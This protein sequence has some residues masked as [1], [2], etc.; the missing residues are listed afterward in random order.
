MDYY[1]LGPDNQ[2]YGPADEATLRRWA[3]EGR[4]F[5][6]TPLTDAARSRVFRASD[7]LPPYAFA[8]APVQ[9]LPGMPPALGASASDGGT[10]LA[11]GG[12]GCLLSFF[13]L[14]GAGGLSALL[15]S[16]WPILNAGP[17]FVVLAGLTY[18]GGGAGLY[19]AL[20]RRNPALA[21]GIGFGLLVGL[22]LLLGLAAICGTIAKQTSQ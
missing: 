18:V 15:G 5:P 13:L 10:G 22:A 2:A 8:H 12:L 6:Q 14:V 11:G 7:V 1:V 16:R 20:R 4:L 17:G 9:P 21:R 19:F 3:G